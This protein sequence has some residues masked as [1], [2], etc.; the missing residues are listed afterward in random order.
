M[1]QGAEA[2]TR[3]S[4]ENGV[5]QQLRRWVGE[6]G[7]SRFRLK[8]CSRKLT[9]SCMNSPFPIVTRSQSSGAARLRLDAPLPLPL[10]PARARPRALPSL[11]PAP[12]PPPS[13]VISRD[14]GGA[15]SPPPL[16]LSAT[17]ST[18]RRLTRVR[19][20]VRARDALG[21]LIQN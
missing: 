20:V 12:V 1:F 13:V 8:D 7:G 16:L 10:P 6:G 17:F 19:G 15:H 18:P 4:F 21:P 11:I 3:S 5:F 2:N 14:R 9:F